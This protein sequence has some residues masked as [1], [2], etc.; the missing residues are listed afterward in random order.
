VTCRQASPVAGA[1]TSAEDVIV[2][3]KKEKKEMTNSDTL[4]RTVAGLCMARTH[5]QQQPVDEVPSI[6]L[7]VDINDNPAAIG[8]GNTSLS[9]LPSGSIINSA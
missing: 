5:A 8:L 9:S 6:D 1:A 7:E 4:V 3:P 2:F